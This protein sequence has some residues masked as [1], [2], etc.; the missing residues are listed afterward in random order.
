MPVVRLTR[1]VVDGTGPKSHRFTLFD[2]TLKGFGLRIFPSGQKSWILEYR[3]A[4][5]GRGVSKRRV[6][7]GPSESLTPDEARRAA[8]QFLAEVGR[9]AELA[10]VA[11]VGSSAVSVWELAALFMRDVEER[12]TAHTRSQYRDV[13]DRLVVPEIGEMTVGAVRKTDVE[14]LR[15]G[16]KH[17]PVLA[18]RMVAVLGAMFSFA[19]KRG[20]TDEVN[21][22]HGVAKYKELRRERALTLEEIE[23]IA[24]A[25]REAETTG[26]AWDLEEAGPASKHLARPDDRFTRMGPHPAAAIRLLILT[27]ARLRQVLGLRWIDVDVEMGSHT[28]VS[29]RSFIS[30]DLVLSFLTTLP[31]VGSYV[32]AGA[33]P[34]KPRT[35]LHRPW[36]L[37]SKRAA[38]SDVVL[39]DLRHLRARYRVDD[40]WHR[41][42]P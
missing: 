32:I 30:E 11:K 12:L 6:T 21:P 31:R 28:D 35:D 24:A 19:E 15:L 39:D 16:H 33:D 7:L 38:L 14:K 42:R 4:G 29:H 36:R 2:D 40:L 41:I 3:P 37:I 9:T 17:T 27:G 1:A 22:A 25:L 26:I 13:L 10:K 34:S 8:S 18:N 5:G 23:L 20:F